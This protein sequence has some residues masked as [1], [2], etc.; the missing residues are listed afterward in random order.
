[1]LPFSVMLAETCVDGRLRGHDGVGVVL[2]Y[3][4]GLGVPPDK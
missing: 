4:E 2:I 1:M 3:L